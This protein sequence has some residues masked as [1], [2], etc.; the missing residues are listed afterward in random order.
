MESGR[1]SDGKF[2]A[3][4]KLGPGNPY[5]K[6]THALRKAMYQAVTESDIYAII[7]K[8]IEQA[9]DGD[10]QS[11]REVLDRTL[12]KS[13]ANDNINITSDEEAANPFREYL[14]RNPK[15]ARDAAILIRSLASDPG[16]AGPHGEQGQMD[17]AGP[18]GPAIEQVARSGDDAE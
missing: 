11:A 15:L 14:D 12:G 7:T 3:G 1:S 8:L 9:R 13:Q 17:V 5:L 6:H 2:S 4:N 10:V 18:S 16:D